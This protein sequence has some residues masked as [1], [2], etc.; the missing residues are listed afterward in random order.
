LCVTL[1]IDQESYI[2]VFKTAH[3]L[4]HFETEESS[5]H[6]YILVIIPFNI[7]LYQPLGSLNNSS[8]YR[9]SDYN[10]ESNSPLFMRVQSPAHPIY[11]DFVALTIL[12]EG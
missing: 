9:F 4:T 3:Y 11:L 5:L 1:V 10:S 12:G 6:P 8:P 2:P 7:I